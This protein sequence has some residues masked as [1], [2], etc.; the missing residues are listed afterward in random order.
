MSGE[1]P[2][3]GMA[4]GVE[5]CGLCL[6]DENCP[7]LAL[8]EAH[9]EDSDRGSGQGNTLVGCQVHMPLKPD[10]RESET[11]LCGLELHLP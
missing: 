10:K 7:S 1:K 4:V 2:F 3:L 9:S 5:W 11:K 6:R 8:K